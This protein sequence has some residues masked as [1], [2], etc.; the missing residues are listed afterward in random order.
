VAADSSIRNAA[1]SLARDTLA[2]LSPDAAT[3][4]AEAMVSQAM[5]DL[6]RGDTARALAAVD[7]LRRHPAELSRNRALVVLPEMLIASHA[8]RPEGA[9]LRAFVD[10]IA[11][12]GCCDLSAYASLALAHAYEVSGDEASALRV[13]RRGLWLFPPRAVATHLREE[14]RL[15][16][17]LGDRAGAIR[18]YRHYLALR[19]DPEP[20]LRAARDSVRAEL[21]RLERGR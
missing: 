1:R 18:A 19:S 9:A 16:A 11:L 21:E 2:P 4:T 17:R 12:E 6:R 14:G 15:A 10:S 7:W 3:R 20:R 8:R 5:W 13:I